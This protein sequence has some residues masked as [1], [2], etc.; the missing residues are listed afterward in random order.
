MYLVGLHIYYKMINGPYNV[1][2][3]IFSG[4]ITLPNTAKL[5]AAIQPLFTIKFV[6]IQGKEYHFRSE[7]DLIYSI[8]L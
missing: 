6:I 7:Y 4:E 5:L 3:T 1:E 2:I 8:T